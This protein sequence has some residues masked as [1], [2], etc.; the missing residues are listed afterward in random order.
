[1]T[2]IIY[3]LWW[4]LLTIVL[5]ISLWPV[6]E[7]SRRVFV[8]RHRNKSGKRTSWRLPITSAAR[9]SRWIR[10]SRTGKSP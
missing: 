6:A 8:L 3:L 5:A 9:V 7:K 4:S 10:K 1:M 2:K